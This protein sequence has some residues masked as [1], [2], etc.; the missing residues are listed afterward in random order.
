LTVDESDN[1]LRTLWSDVLGALSLGG[2]LPADSALRQM[3]PGTTFGPPE[4]LRV[5]AGLAELPSPVVLILDDIHYLRTGA[6]LNSISELIEQQPPS[7]RLVLM[8]RTDPAL[9]LH[10]LR[11]NGGLTEIRSEDLAFT[12]DEAAELFT[13]DGIELTVDQL[14][15]LLSRTQGWSAGLRLAALTLADTDVTEGIARFGGTQRSVS[16]YLIG[17]VLDRR[18]VPDRDFLL[19]TSIA[20]RINESLAASL[21]GRAD[22]Q[23]VL[24]NLVAANA[25]VVS[26]TGTDGWFRYHPLLR[27]LMEHLV[28]REQPDLVAELHATAAEWFA[29]H[30]DPIQSIRHSTAAGE[31]D[32]VGRMLAGSALP[33]ILTADAAA[34]ASALEPAVRRSVQQPT[35]STLLAGA[36]WHYHRR[37]FNAMN[38][39]AVEAT[40]FLPGAPEGLRIPAEILMA[41]TTV[42][43]H[44]GT[45][46]A[47]LVR[48]STHLLSLLDRAPRRLVPAARQYRAIGVNNVGVGQ[49]W[50]G[51]LAGAETNLTAAAVQAEE[52]GVAL[53]LVA[54]HAHL[55][56]RDVMLG[57]LHS[58]H[59]RA[60]AARDVVDRRGWASEPQA[61]GLYVA[62]SLTELAWNRPAAAADVVDAG[63]VASS[64]GGSDHGC[65]LA[66]GIAAIGV[67]AAR[68]D[69]DAARSAAER[70]AAE[71]AGVSDPPDLLGRWCRVALAQAK[72]ISGEPDA[73][74]GRIQRPI[75]GTGF[76]AAV[77][78]VILAKAHLARGDFGALPALLDPLT[79]TDPKFLGPAVDARIMMAI[80]ADR[81]HR[82][83]AA[84]ARITE[85]IDLAAPEG[86]IRPF[87]DARPVVTRLI[88]RHRHVIARH[89]DFTERLV[90]TPTVPLPPAPEPMIGEHLT[91][92][93]LIVLRYMP[94]M[95]KTAEI[96]KD[97]FVSVNTVKSHQRA[98]YR[99]LDVTTR[100]AAVERAR[101]L[102]LV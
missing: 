90:T 101:D 78:R 36:I 32:E 28:H 94:T 72:L 50:A 45:A 59:R 38:R 75:G 27:E 44:R 60:T 15:S 8:T 16:E 63:L 77:E 85:V 54:A 39:D 34:L 47:G 83:T 73:V 79:H 20:E 70:L 97:L 46:A 6:V 3:V 51:D 99:K 1:D 14:Q 100:R 17:E 87:V 42:T 74:F 89:L 102:H 26:L 43:Y 40:E 25:L 23:L 86:L 67:A 80:A 48:S 96:A 19:R 82:G 10:R 57:R 91:E 93:E 5:R 13:R 65:R 92:R 71:L 55:A 58:A 30:G 7:L 81:Q 31:W 37:D 52:L 53:A 95:L 21:T 76:A 24:E 12:P 66:L 56:V 88:T 2:V 69:T 98:I 61:L 11:V 84:L 62:L 41:I 29:A 4:V 68:G 22:S 49:L 64:H 35:L 9:R 18:S 33:L